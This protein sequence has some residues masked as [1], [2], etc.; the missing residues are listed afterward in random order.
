MIVAPRSVRRPRA[1]VAAVPLLLVIAGACQSTAIDHDATTRAAVAAPHALTES[2]SLWT[3][4]LDLDRTEPSLKLSPHRVT[5]FAGHYSDEPNAAS[6]PSP[7]FDL[8]HGEL[9]FQFS[10]KT[11]LPLGLERSDGVPDLWFGYTQQAHWQVGQP[12]GPFR[13]TNYEPEGFL[14]WP[15]RTWGEWGPVELKALG[16]GVSHQSNG[17][18]GA[19]SRSWNRVIGQLAFEFGD[20]TTMLLR[21]WWRIPESQFNDNNPDLGDY[22]GDGDLALEHSFQW[23]GFDLSAGALVRNNLDSH[24]NRGAVEAWLAGPFLHPRLNWYL[25]G[26]SGYGETLIDYDHRQ[27]TIAVGI[28][29]RDW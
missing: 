20:A 5:Y 11:R 13:E 28:T 21:P 29:L 8:E 3:R 26:F 17:R 19:T 24:P 6:N 9:E 10:V 2:A 22:M 7:Q 27:Q 4:Q 18:G 15:A 1:L 23:L 12:S 25:Q 14:L 16:V